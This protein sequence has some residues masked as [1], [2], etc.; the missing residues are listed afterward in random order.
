M[1]LRIFQ[2][3]SEL[4]FPL[5]FERLCMYI[6]LGIY[7][8]HLQANVLSLHHLKTFANRGFLMLSVVIVRDFL[9]ISLLILREF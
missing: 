3:F 6:S 5:F 8:T 4:S 7:L 1:L 2:I 9:Q